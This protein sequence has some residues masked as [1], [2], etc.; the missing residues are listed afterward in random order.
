[1]EGKSQGELKF[2]RNNERKRIRFVLRQDKTKKVVANFYIAED[3]LCE[4]KAY[5]G[6]DKSF[7]FFAYE[8]S[9]DQPKVERYVIKLGNYQSN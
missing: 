3:P 2:L 4:L 8:C 1:M 9:E 6:S 7:F 5:M